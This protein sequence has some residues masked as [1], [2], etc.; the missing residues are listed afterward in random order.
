MVEKKLLLGRTIPIS[1]Y[2]KKDLTLLSILHFKF[3][4]LNFCIYALP[5]H[6]IFMNKRVDRIIQSIHT[7]KKSL[8]FLKIAALIPHIRLIGISGGLSMLQGEKRDDVDIFIIAS[9]KRVWSARLTLLLLAQLWGVRRRRNERNPQGTVCFNLFF[10]EEDLEIPAYKRN[11]Y[12]AHEVVQMKP[13][14]VKGDIY[15]RFLRENRWIMDFFPNVHTIFTRMRQ[16]E[17]KDLTISHKYESIT[18][19]LFLLFEKWGDC[20]EFLCK[21]FER[22]LIEKHCT[23]EIITDTQLWFFPHDMEKELREKKMI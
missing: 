22:F 16:Q 5:P 10:D 17:K 11:E 8:F 21:K 4:I 19:M 12:V 6:G 2:L 20:V 13:V 18:R 23:T 14:F 15:G 7:I 1:K 9:Q 3:S